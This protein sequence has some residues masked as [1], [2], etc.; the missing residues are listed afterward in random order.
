MEIRLAGAHL[1]AA[2]ALFLT[3]ITFGLH[4]VWENL[5]CPLLFVHREGDATQTAMLIVTVGDV[6]MTWLAHGIIGIVTGRWLWILGPV[7]RREWLVLM[8]IALVMSTSIES[9]ALTTGR[10]SYTELNPLIPGTSVSIV[11]VAQLLVLFPVS[12][13]LTGW[14]LRLRRPT[15]RPLARVTTGSSQ[16][17]LCTGSSRCTR[18][19][20]TSGDRRLSNPRLFASRNMR[21]FSASTSPTSSL[22]PRSRQ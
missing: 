15:S 14:L 5:Q 22:V 12:F 4:Y 3:A 21:L 17:S 2:H 10:W 9:Y 16:L 13:A 8:L 1:Y 11:P 6:A 19:T 20:S 7:G 18:I